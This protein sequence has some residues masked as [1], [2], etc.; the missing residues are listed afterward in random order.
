VT[1][2]PVT[3]LRLVSHRWLCSLGGIGMW[4][5]NASRD[6]WRTCF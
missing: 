5:Y 4:G 1:N 6:N 3:T 2:W